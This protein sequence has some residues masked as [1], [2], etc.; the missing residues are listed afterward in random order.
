MSLADHGA[1]RPLMTS[2]GL[3]GEAPRAAP[4]QPVEAC[5]ESVI[6]RGAAVDQQPGH[7]IEHAGLVQVAQEGPL[8]EHHVVRTEFRPTGEDAVGDRPAA[9][10]FARLDAHRH[11]FDAFHGF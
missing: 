8:D 7:V 10:P 3:P 9:P 6:G 5:Q 4:H 1:H 11:V 2:A